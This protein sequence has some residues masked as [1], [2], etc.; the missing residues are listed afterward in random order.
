M[1]IDRESREWLEKLHPGLPGIFRNTLQVCR[2]AFAAV[3]RL[4]YDRMNGERP[5]VDF[6]TAVPPLARTFLDAMITVSFVRD[7]PFEHVERYYKGGLCAALAQQNRLVEEYGANSDW[8]EHLASLKA[9]ID[10]HEQGNAPH[11]S[12]SPR[13]P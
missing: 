11:T 2:A 5:A 3:K 6:S 4:C 10:L 1:R 13:F 7:Q 9:W 12:S 8:R